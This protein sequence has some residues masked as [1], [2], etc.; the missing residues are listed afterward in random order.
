MTPIG[1][2]TVNCFDSRL[3]SGDG[4]PGVIV[5]GQELVASLAE[6]TPELAHAG[7]LPS[8]EQHERLSVRMAQQ[9]GR[10]V[11]H[12]TNAVLE[13]TAKAAG[14]ETPGWQFAGIAATAAIQIARNSC[15]RSAIFISCL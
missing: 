10:A 6:L 15:K 8:I 12:S 13:A 7:L 5:Q 14:S 1:F 3:G 11:V 9:R 4:V 2:V